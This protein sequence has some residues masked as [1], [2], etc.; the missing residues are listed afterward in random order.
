MPENTRC[1]P[2]GW[3]ICG[4]EAR[5]GAGGGP[6]AT[7]AGDHGAV[8]PRRSGGLALAFGRPSQLLSLVPRRHCASQVQLGD[9]LGRCHPVACVTGNLPLNS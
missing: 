9:V 6:A 2:D 4:G 3:L 5:R 7:V 8:E 1:M